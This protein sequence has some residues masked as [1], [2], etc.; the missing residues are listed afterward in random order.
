M[1]AITRTF[2]RTGPLPPTRSN[3]LLL[4]HAQQH[5]LGL[6]GQL[7]DLVEEDRA[8]VGQLEATL[9]PLQ[10]PG[11][12]ALLVTEQLRRDERRRNRRAI[13]GDESPGGAWRSLVDRPGDELLA[14]AGL[15]GDQH[16]RI[17]RRHLGHVR[18]NRPKRRRDADDLLE[19]G[20]LVDLLTEDDVLAL[21]PIRQGLDPGV[22]ADVLGPVG[23]VVVDGVRDDVQ[24]LHGGR[25]APAERGQQLLITL[26]SHGGE[27]LTLNLTLRADVRAVCT[28]SQDAGV[29]RC[30]HGVPP[31]VESIRH[32]ESA[33]IVPRRTSRRWQV[34]GCVLAAFC[35]GERTPGANEGSFSAAFDIRTPTEIRPA[36][37]AGVYLYRSCWRAWR[38]VVFSPYLSIFR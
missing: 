34:Q 27:V 28:P 15:A 11:E 36:R 33:T 12:R 2:T 7:A 17:R 16:G 38:R 14:R 35:L 25:R 4:Q 9:A 5:D 20:G 32:K 30:C 22:G 6:G 23:R 1:A 8:A 21:Q 29:I 10:G 19:H 24:A 26:D 13:H 37:T 18:Q 31:C 3:S